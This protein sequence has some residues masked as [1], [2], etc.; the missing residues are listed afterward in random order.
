VGAEDAVLAAHRQQQGL[1]KTA[2]GDNL[3]SAPDG[4]LL[5]PRLLSESCW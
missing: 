4:C 1:Q 2:Q 5:E 3:S